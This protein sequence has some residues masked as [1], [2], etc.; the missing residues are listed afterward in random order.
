MIGRSSERSDRSNGAHVDGLNLLQRFARPGDAFYE[1]CIGTNFASNLHL[2]FRMYIRYVES[3]RKTRESNLTPGLMRDDTQ[4]SQLSLN[5][6]LLLPSKGA[7][8]RHVQGCVVVVAKLCAQ[9]LALRKADPQVAVSGTLRF[10]RRP[11]AAILS[12]RVPIH[13]R[14]IRCDRG[15]P[16]M[17][18]TTIVAWPTPP[19]RFHARGHPRAATA[20]APAWPQSCAGS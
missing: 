9:V 19:W 10:K 15:P 3:T 18:E 14:T 7:G 5:N 20:S 12:H 16:S 8:Q 11:S 13:Y 4:A 6:C 2:P 1:S 17:A